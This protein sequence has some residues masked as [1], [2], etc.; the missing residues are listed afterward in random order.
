MFVAIQHDRDKI[1]YTKKVKKTG[2][3]E[4]MEMEELVNGKRTY[5]KEEANSPNSAK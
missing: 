4:Q 5:M 2:E 3:E 1:R